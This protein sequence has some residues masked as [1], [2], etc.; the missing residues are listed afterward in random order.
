MDGDLCIW[1][2]DDEDFSADDL[3]FGVK[4]KRG[5][6]SRL[7]GSRVPCSRNSLKKG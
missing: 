5:G 4:L 7:L 3:P 1:G 2:K 6:N